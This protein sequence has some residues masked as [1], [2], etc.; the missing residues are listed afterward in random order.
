MKEAIDLI[1]VDGNFKILK[2]YAHVKPRRIRLCWHARHCLEM[3]AG[4][5]T[6]ANTLDLVQQVQAEYIERGIK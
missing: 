2:S 4:V 6:Q 5:L 3:Q 1:F